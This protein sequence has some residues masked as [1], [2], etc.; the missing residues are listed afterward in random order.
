LTDIFVV[1]FWKILG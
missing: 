1:S